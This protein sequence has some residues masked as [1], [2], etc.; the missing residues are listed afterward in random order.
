MEMTEAEW[1][2]SNIPRAMLRALIYPATPTQYLRSLKVEDRAKANLFDRKLR[3]LACA[4]VRNVWDLL[5][6]ERSR[7]A[8]EV[9]ER[10]ADGKALPK[11][12]EAANDD[13]DA[14]AQDLWRSGRLEALEVARREVSEES[15]RPLASVFGERRE[16]RVYN[17][18]SAAA[19]ITR[20]KIAS[21]MSP[22]G[23][24][25]SAWAAVEM[26]SRSAS[27]ATAD[28]AE[29]RAREALLQAELE[30]DRGNAHWYYEDARQADLL[31]CIFGNPFLPSALDPAQLT[32][33]S[34]ELAREIESGR[35]F[36][37][38]PDLADALEKAGCHDE[39]ILG[40]CRKLGVHA[41]GCWVID[42][43]RG[44]G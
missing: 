21:S 43:I 22:R 23:Y 20:H 10:Y 25:E 9:T 33:E 18:A 28:I 37:F 26:A 29:L 32:P 19:S 2:S 1:L 5:E 13:A 41:R 34:V 12:L 38:M 11:E 6:D 16:E 7:R 35:A 40:H 8:V 17:A 30:V 3:L 42:A 31:R 39:A 27:D 36:E 14:A 4:C 15:E 44:V 24:Y